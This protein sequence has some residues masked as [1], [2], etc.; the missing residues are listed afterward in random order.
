MTNFGPLVSTT[1][2]RFP[3]WTPF[4]EAT[5]VTVLFSVQADVEWTEMSEK[6][7]PVDVENAPVWPVPSKATW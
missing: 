1:T 4:S 7:T 2:E 5:Q 3:T 6:G